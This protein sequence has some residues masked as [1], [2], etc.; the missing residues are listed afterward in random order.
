MTAPNP[1]RLLQKSLEVAGRISHTMRRAHQ[2]VAAAE[3]LTSGS[4]SCHLGAAESSSE[5]FLGALI[6]YDSEVK[7]SILGVSRGCV[8]T[9]DC[10]HQMAD[11]IAKLLSADFAVAVTGAGGPEPEEDQPAGT[12]FIAV[13]TPN[14]TSVAK[15]LFLGG[16]SEVVQKTTFHALQMLDAATTKMLDAATTNLVSA[17]D[18]PNSGEAQ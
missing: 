8:I 15:H 3:S 17:A 7:F 11:G 10:A 13:H 18:G 9:A 1:D 6:A 12:V 16:P 5:W 4:I 14:G 2:K